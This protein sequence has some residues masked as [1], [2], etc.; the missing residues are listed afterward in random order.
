MKNEYMLINKFD[1]KY[2]EIF[3]RQNSFI[4]EIKNYS[5]VISVYKGNVVKLKVI[6][7]IK[8]NK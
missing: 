2:Y 7:S 3:N 8:E 1:H 4:N 5:K 6:C